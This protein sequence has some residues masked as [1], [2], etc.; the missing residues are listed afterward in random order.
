MEILERTENDLLNRVELKFHWDHPKSPTP[1]LK[2]MVTAVTKAEPGS[3]K[4]LVFVKDV[5]TRFGMTRTSGIA[6][7]YQSVEASSIEPSYILDR[8]KL[9]DEDGK[10][11]SNDESNSEDSEDQ[12]GDE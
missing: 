2:E 8:H 5:S 11:D 3:K 4:E 12:G 6:M 7:I 10:S 1:S 9:D